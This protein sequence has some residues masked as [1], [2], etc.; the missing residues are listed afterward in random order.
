MD[1]YRRTQVKR[2]RLELT[3]LT[4][5]TQ[6]HLICQREEIP[7]II[8]K[9]QSRPPLTHSLQRMVMYKTVDQYHREPMPIPP[10]PHRALDSLKFPPQQKQTIETGL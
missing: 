9:E 10:R 5:T 6:V 4:G 7:K 3:L 1:L 8:S 2:T